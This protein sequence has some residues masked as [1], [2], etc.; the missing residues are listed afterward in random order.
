MEKLTLAIVSIALESWE[1]TA[2]VS[3]RLIYA[4]GVCRMTGVSACSAFIVFDARVI[5]SGRRMD[6]TWQTIASVRS[7]FIDAHRVQAAMMSVSSSFNFA[8]VDI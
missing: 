6:E 8:L 1:T 2:L 5:V 3:V 4:S 7:G